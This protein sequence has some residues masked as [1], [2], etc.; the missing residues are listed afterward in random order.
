MDALMEHV[1]K[2]KAELP[3]YAYGMREA[4]DFIAAHPGCTKSEVYQN[5]GVYPK[6]FGNSPNS[7]KRLALRGMIY[8][9][10]RSNRARLYVWQPVERP[11]GAYV[12]GHP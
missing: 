6:P 1:K 12:P 10:G 4:L 11:A 3:S 9:L 5:T 2:L 8:D 7:I